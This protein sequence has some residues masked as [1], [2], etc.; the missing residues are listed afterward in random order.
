MPLLNDS[1]LTDLTLKTLYVLSYEAVLEKNKGLSVTWSPNCLE[2]TNRTASELRNSNILRNL[3]GEAFHDWLSNLTLAAAQEH[4][5]VWTH[6]MN[7]GVD[8]VHVSH[9][10]YP[11]GNGKVLGCILRLNSGNGGISSRVAYQGGEAEKNGGVKSNFISAMSHEIRTP[12]NAIVGVSH[13]ALSTT[14]DPVMRNYLKKIEQ[15]ATCLMA[16]LNDI[17]DYSK[18]DAGDMQLENDCFRVEDLFAQ[19]KSAF[20]PMAREK[21]LELTMSASED[22][23]AIVK[24]DPLRISQVLTNLIGNAL[25]FTEQ[26]AV[27]LFCTVAENR[28]S[29]L[30][31]RFTVQDNSKGM[32]TGQL[33]NGFTAFHQ[34]DNSTTIKYGGTGLGL[35]ISRKLAE[36]LG[37]SLNVA[38]TPGGA[39]KTIFTCRVERDASG[40]ER[41]ES[42]ENVTPQFQG[43][44]ILL[45]ED[46]ATNRE[47][48]TALMEAANLKVVA[49]DNGQTA[50]DILN[51]N[52]EKSLFSLILMDLQMPVMDG[53][54][55]TE[56]IRSDPR[57]S[58]LPIIALTAY[59]SEAERKCCLRIG[60]QG[61]LAK[62]IN[63]GVFYGLLKHY[64]S[65]PAAA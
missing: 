49:A 61:H 17:L 29:H 28:Q 27:R 32:N 16:L 37:G 1:L 6:T 65:S 7:T 8:T 15:S 38:G 23:P 62:P 48:A 46:N 40:E 9:R 54:Q 41:E 42:A 35:S 5:Q 13:L 53:Y 56:A 30:V 51:R 24:G 52:P 50:L 22:V 33:E 12:M 31:L 4:V 47:I 55:A 2:L 21:R 14:K 59:T 57:W 10:L 64:L 18:I 20:A 19:L 11:L 36:A 34:T 60:M 39:L 26:G 25:L 43:Q 3:F 44:S 63:A 45:V 58:A